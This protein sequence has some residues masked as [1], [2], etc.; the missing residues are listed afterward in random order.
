[1]SATAAFSPLGLR[2]ILVG[3]SDAAVSRDTGSMLVTYAL[4]SCIAV[5]MF[6]P[7]ARVGGMLHIMLPDSA[8]DARK[9]Q[10]NPFTFA[11]T[12]VPALLKKMNSSGAIDQRITVRLVGGAQVMNDGGLFSIG[13]R[14]HTAVRKVLWKTGLLVDGEAVGGDV[15]RTVRLEISTGRVWVREAGL[16]D[17]EIPLKEPRYAR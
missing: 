3:I 4:G 8:L 5:C 6:D 15:S 7:V 1:M 16:S 14:N 9:A 11:D 12:G 13:K 2:Q 17:L 10:M